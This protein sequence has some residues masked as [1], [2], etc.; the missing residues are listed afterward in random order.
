M[1][2]A[3]PVV[4][5]LLPLALLPWIIHLLMRLRSR[6]VVWGASWVLERALARLGT[7]GDWDQ[8]ILIGIRCLACAALIIAFARPQGSAGERSSGSGIHRILVID[9]TLSMQAGQGETQRWR[10]GIALLQDMVATWGRGERWS[11]L[12]VGDE[13]AW[14]VRDQELS[15]GD[16]AR[17]LLGD[18]VCSRGATPIAAALDQAFAACGSGP[19]EVYILSDDQES[20]WRGAVDLA[21]P[22]PERVR[23]AWICPPLVQ[24][25]NLDVIALR[26]STDIALVGHPVRLS[27]T[28]RHHG[29]RPATG[30]S[31][32]FLADGRILGGQRLSLQPGQHLEIHHDAVFTEAGDVALSVRLSDDA[33]DVDNEVHAA[34][35]V[36]GDLALTVLRDQQSASL[37]SCWDFLRIAAR[38]LAASDGD[39]AA[40]FPGATLTWGLHLDQLDDALALSPII[41]CDGGRRLEAGD[42]ARLA[43]WLDLGRTLILCADDRIDLERWRQEL[44]G[45]GLLPAELGDLRVE[46]LGSDRGMTLQRP[47]GADNPL[48]G[49]ADDAEGDLGNLVCFIRREVTGLVDGSEVVLRFADGAPFAILRRHQPGAVLLLLSGLNGRSGNLTVRETFLPLLIR[50]LTAAWAASEPP[51]TVDVGETIAVR[52]PAGSAVRGATLSLPGEAGLAMQVDPGAG[53]TEVLLPGGSPRDGAASILLLGEGGSRRI[54]IGIQ[55]AR[56][57]GDLGGL[58]DTARQGLVEALHLAE[59]TDA[60]S[61]DAL[62]SAWRGAEERQAWLVIIMLLALAGELLFLRRF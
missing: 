62:I 42:G 22:D 36:R 56:E 45:S 39:G 55:A 15:D 43:R 20:A 25:E 8:R 60:E 16:A 19:A 34:L 13:V 35:T 17:S 49:F 3:H 40:L 37:D 46:T 33:L 53:A 51:R 57:D 29:D 26:P 24:R 1:S 21:R 48:A 14:P 32:D 28:V 2:F 50:L 58:P 44:G 23:V 27:A 12:S 59:V 5:W 4:L 41:V 30:V 47:V 31:L 7:R 38:A 11:L 61:L 52:L 6:R 10:A 9:A 54:P 18:L